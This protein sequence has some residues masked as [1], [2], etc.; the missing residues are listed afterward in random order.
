MRLS[1]FLALALAIAAPCIAL[2]DQ[3]LSSSFESKEHLPFILRYAEWGYLTAPQVSVEK[4]NDIVSLGSHRSRIDMGLVKHSKLTSTEFKGVDGVLGFGF[5]NVSHKGSLVET[6]IVGGSDQPGSFLPLTPQKFSIVASHGGG[7]LQLGGYN[8]DAVVEGPIM[9]DVL[10]HDFQYGNEFGYSFALDDFKVCG[11]SIMPKG[12]HFS[13]LLQAGPVCVGL[14]ANV[15]GYTGFS[16]LAKYLTTSR[17]CPKDGL[18][19]IVA[20]GHTFSFPASQLSKD[21]GCVRGH[22][23]NSNFISLGDPFFRNFLVLHDL[24]DLF[25]NGDIRVGLARRNLKCNCPAP[26]IRTAFVHQMT[27]IYR[28]NIGSQMREKSDRTGVEHIALTSTPYDLGVRYLANV[29][30]GSPPQEQVAPPL[31]PLQLSPINKPTLA[32]P[33]LH[34][35]LPSRSILAPHPSPLQ[36]MVLDTGSVLIALFPVE[37][38]A[39]SVFFWILPVIAILGL[40]VGGGKTV[41]SLTKQ[42]AEEKAERRKYSTFQVCSVTRVVV[43]PFLTPACRQAGVDTNL[44]MAAITKEGYG[45]I[46]DYKEIADQNKKTATIQVSCCAQLAAANAHV[47]CARSRTKCSPSASALSC[48]TSRPSR[49]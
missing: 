46:P 7:E 24:T 29:G 10:P 25:T 6:L 40:V 43:A 26:N 2:F 16:P 45:A 14:P 42:R 38:G 32:S 31:P 23:Q 9:L 3:R 18:V 19:E 47:I 44:K 4:F 33:H 13:A 30:V 36:M 27:M 11:V 1:L 41:Y 5:S 35:V 34:P 17:H 39:T 15:V 21:E 49:I 20:S 37:V 22:E 12:V 28:Y 48:R 8:P